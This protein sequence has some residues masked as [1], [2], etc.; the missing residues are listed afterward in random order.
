M[1]AESSSQHL[2]D[3]KSLLADAVVVSMLGGPGSGKG[4]Q[5]QRLSQIFDIEHVS[6]GNLLRD[7]MDR[8]DSQYGALIKHN[9][10][11]GAVGPKE[12]TVGII[13]SHIVKL[14]GQ[15]K[16]VFL[17]DGKLAALPVQHRRPRSLDETGFPRSVDRAEYFE[18]TICPIQLVVVLQCSE[19]ALFDRL[20]SRARFDDTRES[21]QKRIDT[22]NYTT[23]AVIQHYREQGKVR[24]VDGEKDVEAVSLALED[25]FSDV[26]KRLSG[27]GLQQ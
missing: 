9:M 20:V 15:G 7:E 23:S 6:V 24:V 18:K 11:V 3:G 25:V 16:R 21:I 4:T 8:A 2:A 1:A 14:A 13:E 17:L 22:F 5:C 26:A 10:L 12:M 27:P 19:S